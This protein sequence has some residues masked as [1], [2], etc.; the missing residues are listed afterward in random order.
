MGSEVSEKV[1]VAAAPETVWRLV[2]DVTRMGE[3]SPETRQCR[4]VG[5]AS[6]PTV[7]A[8]FVGA[9]RNRLWRW[10]TQCRVTEAVPGTSFAF[11]VS[12]AGQ[13][14]A[15]WRYEIRPV[16]GGCEVTESTSDR[17]SA[18]M[19]VMGLVGSGVRDRA[20]HNRVTMRATLT[21]LSAAAQKAS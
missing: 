4:W 13:P 7:G 14:I 10:S 1:R 15:H 16:D 20:S 2:S 6:A 8:R 11:D 21:A 18:L 12:F 5:G 17:R 19:H 3:W 9:N